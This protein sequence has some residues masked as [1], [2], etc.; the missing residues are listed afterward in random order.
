MKIVVFGAGSIGVYVGCSLLEAGAD[1][2]LVGR[3]RMGERIAKHGVVLTDQLGRRTEFDGGSI[4]W[5]ED[6]GRL[7]EADLIL[8]TVKSADTA[9]AADAIHAYA[10]P[11]AL[12]LSLQ[13]GV[14][15]VA[16]LRG[17][18]KGMVVAGGMVPFNVVQMEDG[19]F[20]RGTEG[21]LMVEA[22][23]AIGQWQA[24]FEK[25]HLPLVECADF[26][27]VQWGKL[28]LNLNNPV[29]ALSGLPLKAELS[30]RA[31]RRSLALLI[32]EA[33]DVLQAA[34]IAP[35]KVARVAP[36]LLPRILRLPDWL[37]KRVAGA[38]LRIDPEARSSMWE[39]L[40]A[41]RRTEIDYL[42]GAVVSLARSLGR[43]APANER[44]VELIRRAESG[45]G[46]EL[47]G[48]VLYHLLSTPSLAGVVAGIKA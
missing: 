15:N 14:G 40:Q 45:K 48:A 8:V 22:L 16:T 5:C 28:L 38:M 39:D 33:L 37:F 12:V 1:V 2:L 4:P 9:A 19:R 27:S 23:P 44:V 26:A 31:Y 6:P 47:D 10:R 46:K 24:V 18:L 7:A 30:Q 17:R 36:G 34:D 25:A 20:H 35:A 11:S 13:N 3:A 41:G 43:K 42:N 29:N 21:E 32:E